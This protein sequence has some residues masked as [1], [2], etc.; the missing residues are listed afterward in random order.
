[1]TNFKFY[2]AKHV[3]YIV[4]G[5]SFFAKRKVE[6]TWQQVD[7]S[8][9]NSRGHYPSKWVVKGQAND[10]DHALVLINEM[11]ENERQEKL[12]RN[13][14]LEIEY[15]QFLFDAKDFVLSGQTIEVTQENLIKVLYGLNQ[16]N[17]G[18]WT[19]P[20]MTIGY[21]AHQYDCDGKTATTIN[22]DQP[23]NIDG[24]MISKFK[25]ATNRG[26]LN[27]YYSLR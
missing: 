5:N 11:Q 13:S 20:T 22:L 3:G 7:E 21:S 17:W 6:E 10:F 9:F 23:I 19:L 24:Q 26:H 4:F 15:Q 16:M 1:M 2:F 25:T 27:E 18:S 12:N 14:K 8:F